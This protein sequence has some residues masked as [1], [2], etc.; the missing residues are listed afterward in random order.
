MLAANHHK[1]RNP[2][3][4]LRRTEGAE[5]VCNSIGRITISTNQIPPHT[6]PRD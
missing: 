3:G 6:A 5:R 1:H 4:G 2:N